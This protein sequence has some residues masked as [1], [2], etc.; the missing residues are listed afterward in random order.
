MELC[1]DRFDNNTIRCRGRLSIDGTQVS[2]TLEDPVRDLGDHG[3][4]KIY[5][6]T[7]IPA[8]RYKVDITYSPK[9]KK[10]M[11]E[12]KDV[13]YFTGI[14]LHSGNTVDHTL[15]CP[16]VGTTHTKDGITG[17]FDVMPKIFDRIQKALIAKEEVWVT[18]QNNFPPEDICSQP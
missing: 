5:G 2:L 14:R 9:F 13:E 1:I 3:K 17:G 7:A 8:G 10:L 15:G 12:F 4:G 16:L 11:V 18:V 6:K